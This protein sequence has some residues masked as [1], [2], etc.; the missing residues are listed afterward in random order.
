VELD[1]DDELT[2]DAL[3]VPPL[4]HLL[5][6]T[7]ALHLLLYRS[8]AC[9]QAQACAAARGALLVELDHDDELT[10][11]ALEVLK[12]AFVAN[13]D[14]G[15]LYGETVRQ[16]EGTNDTVDYGSVWGYGYVSVGVYGCVC[17]LG[18]CGHLSGVEG[19]GRGALGCSGVLW[20]AGGGRDLAMCEGACLGGLEGTPG[21]AERTLARVP[22][23]C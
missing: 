2:P 10:P 16:Y 4:T 21:R 15:L 6:L 7:I 20:R 17:G 22:C 23:R 19:R 8:P 5:P 3:E 18:G 9:L 1:H 13:P 14:A 12:D 11:D